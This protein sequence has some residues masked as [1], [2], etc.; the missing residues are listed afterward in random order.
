MSAGLG[1]HAMAAAITDVRANFAAPGQLDVVLVVDGAGAR[2]E[3]DEPRARCCAAA[4]PATRLLA[5]WGRRSPTRPITWSAQE[6]AADA[7]AAFLW[8]S[9]PPSARWGPGPA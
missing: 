5:L 4:D 3:L 2:L 8:A 7:L 6:S 9:S 1:H